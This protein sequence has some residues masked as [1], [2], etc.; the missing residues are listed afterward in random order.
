[1]KL[2]GIGMAL[3]IVLSGC[4]WVDTQ[5]GAE[6]VVVIDKYQ[7][8]SCQRL[9][10]TETKTLNKLWLLERETQKI[11]EEL[12]TLARNQANK[13]G[14]NA[15]LPLSAPESGKQAFVVYKC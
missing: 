5:P 12:L 7:A 11:H 10:T 14:G 4:S 9:G 6:R 15:L 2:I 1:M 3:A 13:M 8:E